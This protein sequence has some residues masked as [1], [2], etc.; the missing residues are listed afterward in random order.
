MII[1]VGMISSS[2]AA[3]SAPPTATQTVGAGIMPNPI[4]NVVSASMEIVPLSSTKGAVS[5]GAIVVSVLG[6]KNA[7]RTP[8]EVVVNVNVYDRVM[9]NGFE[10]RLLLTIPPDKLAVSQ[11]RTPGAPL[12]FTASLADKRIFPNGL[13]YGSYRAEA[14]V[15]LVDVRATTDGSFPKQRRLIEVGG[16]ALE[17]FV[18]Q[19]FGST[20]AEMGGEVTVMPKLVMTN[21][22]LFWQAHSSARAA[23]EMHLGLIR[24]WVGQA[25]APILG[26]PKKNNVVASEAIVG[27]VS[28]LPQIVLK[29]RGQVFEQTPGL[30]NGLH[31]ILARGNM[32]VPVPGGILYLSTR[33]TVTVR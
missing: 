13:P 6:A 19:L 28:H 14:V 24:S 29:F 5:P 12:V 7:T 23:I 8:G 3:V 26:F 16:V 15:S 9:D 1:A 22:K 25:N 31:G 30:M 27:E 21:P 4:E 20:V 18:N 11:A 33:S 17:F 32:T 2:V 10:E